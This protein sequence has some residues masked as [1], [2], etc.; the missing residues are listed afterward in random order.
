[1]ASRE[2]TKP[3]LIE[4]G[5]VAVPLGLVRQIRRGLVGAGAFVIGW[6]LLARTVPDYLLPPPLAVLTAFAAELTTPATYTL[7]GVDVQLTEMLVVLLQSLA[8]YLPGLIMGVGLGA[9]LGLALGYSTRIDE[10][11][12]PAVSL[13]RPIPPLAWMGFVI[14]WVGIGHAGAAVIV[15]IGSFWITLFSAYGGVEELPEEWIEVGRSLGVESDLTMLRKVVVPGA[16][17][18]IFTGIR[19]SIGR[20]WMIVVAAEL[21]GAP[22]IGYRIIHT[23]QS[24]SMD[25]SMAYMLALGLAYLGSDVGFRLLRGVVKT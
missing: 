7:L 12:S 25:V 6:T 5:S 17:P 23:A 9:P 8:H 18:S 4:I 20:S 16:A 24:L 1:M 19:T 14:V 13:L 3:Q 10:Y 2:L 22:G 15:A 21:F 11:L